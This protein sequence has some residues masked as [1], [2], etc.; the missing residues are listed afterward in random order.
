MKCKQ[1]GASINTNAKFCEYCGSVININGHDYSFGGTGECFV[2]ESVFSIMG[3]SIVIGKALQPLKIGD[4]VFFEKKKFTII[5][6]QLG[7][8]ISTNI[9]SGDNCGLILN[10]FSKK[11]LKQGDKLVFVNEKN[12]I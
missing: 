4:E 11:D 1:C 2:V 3:R 9:N 8:Q 5:N 6:M 10:N 7:R 12:K